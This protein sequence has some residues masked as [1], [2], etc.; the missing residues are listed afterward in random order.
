MHFVGEFNCQEISFFHATE[1]NSSCLTFA[2]V[3]ISCYDKSKNEFDE[4]QKVGCYSRGS[5]TS[6]EKCRKL[7]GYKEM[8]YAEFVCINTE[9]FS[10]IFCIYSFWIE[11]ILKN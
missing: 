1:G 9:R 2:I 5:T 4:D 7:K 3:V 11:N 10:D 6:W 8:I